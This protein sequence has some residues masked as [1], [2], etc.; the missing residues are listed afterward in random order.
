M[1]YLVNAI[2]AK[3]ID[4]YAIHTIGIPSIVLMERAALC[5]YEQAIKMVR[6]EDGRILVVCG[7]G[8]NGADGIAAARMLSFAD[9]QVELLYVGNVQNASEEWK[10][11]NQI[12]QNLKLSVK[13][14]NSLANGEY[15]KRGEYA[16]ILD[17]IFGIGLA[18]EIT[19]VFRTVIEQINTSQTKVLS[20]DI[21]SGVAAD[22]GMVLGCAVRA[23]ATVTFG[24][25]KMGIVLYPGADYSG[26]V[27]VKDIGFVP[28]ALDYAKLDA[29]TLDESDLTEFIKLRPS[30]SHKG[31]FGRILIIAGSEN[32]AGAAYLSA[33]AAYRMG[34]GLVRIYTPET[35]RMI[36]QSLL[37]EAILTTY[38]SQSFDGSIQKEVLDWADCI[39]FG[40]GIG[41]EAY[42]ETMLKVVLY[43]CSAPIVLDADGL[44]VLASSEDLQL[45]MTMQQVGRNRVIVTP[46]LGEMSAL[47]EE[48]VDKIQENKVLAARNFADKWHCVCVLK[49]A[50][51]VVAQPMKER[52]FVNHLGNS[53]MA[54]AGS[55]DVLTGIIVALLAQ[56]Y[57]MGQAASLGVL[58]HAIA[59][60]RAARQLGER[61][62]MAS[63]MIEAL[64]FLREIC[65]VRER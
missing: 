28:G 18:R 21:P 30:N 35:N 27:I 60:D 44:R 6:P 63:D 38:P 52:Y 10:Q 43:D 32:M 23:D 31:T 59:G 19:G 51:T 1:E 46:H 48:S 26:K 65:D 54:T 29:Y 34:A 13:T 37:P 17:A 4:Q 20:V 64:T 33:K 58:I 36:L 49:D 40:P 22:T 5:V 50:R 61:A 14:V 39:V 53:G 9:Y 25:H 8:N 42:V 12:I 62:V 24:F 16:L 55:G 57:D 45:S 2:Q 15:I 7:T 47:I 3:N 41:R 56:G 11:Q